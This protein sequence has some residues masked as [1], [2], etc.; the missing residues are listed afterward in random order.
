MCTP[1]RPFWH[2]IPPPYP[3]APACLPTF[4]RVSR[5]LPYIQMAG[6][7]AWNRQRTPCTWNENTHQRRKPCA[8]Y[9]PH[10]EIG[11]KWVSARVRQIYRKAGGVSLPHQDDVARST[12]ACTMRPIWG[13][14]R[15]HRRTLRMWPDRAGGVEHTIPL[16]PCLREGS[17]CSKSTHNLTHPTPTT[18]TTTTPSH[19]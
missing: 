1:L 5:S 15:A 3:P 9:K 16:I 8:D 10:V 17:K 13:N 2:F 6:R 19:K 18:T 4:H 12:S 14:E 11:T 7:T